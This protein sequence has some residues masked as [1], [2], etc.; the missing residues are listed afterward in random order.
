M[1]LADKLKLKITGKLTPKT[2]AAPVKKK[3]EKKPKPCEELT[4]ALE[5]LLP[6]D[7]PKPVDAPKQAQD[8]PRTCCGTKR[9]KDSPHDVKC[10]TLVG[11]KK[12]HIGFDLPG[13]RFP[14]GTNMNKTYHECGFWECLLVIPGVLT[15]FRAKDGNAL[16]VEWKVTKQ[17]IAWLKS[18]AAAPVVPEVQS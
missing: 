4:K 16:Q 9:G 7:E 15:T 11:K 3:K 12:L 2:D 17:Y 14:V 13:G 5:I 1:N 10:H 6:K 8:K 18:E